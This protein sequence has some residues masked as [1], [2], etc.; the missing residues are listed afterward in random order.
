MSVC[1]FVCPPPHKKK[2]LGR[3]VWRLLV[4]EHMHRFTKLGNSFSFEGLDNILEFEMFWGFQVLRDFLLL[5]LD[6]C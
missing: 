6:I 5:I 4:E 3:V 1:V 2:L